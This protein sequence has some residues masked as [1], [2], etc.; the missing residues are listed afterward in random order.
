MYLKCVNKSQI[1]P[2]SGN[3]THVIDI[4]SFTAYTAA[5]SAN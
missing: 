5:G 4:L 2:I 3:A 1:K